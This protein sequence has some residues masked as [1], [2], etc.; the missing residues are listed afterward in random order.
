MKKI[1]MIMTLFA[2]MM[3]TM[4][5]AC[6]KDDVVFSPEVPYNIELSNSVNAW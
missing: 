6:S 5:T 1:Y 3:A 4:F 2:I